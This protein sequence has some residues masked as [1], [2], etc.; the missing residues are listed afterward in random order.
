FLER[1]GGLYHPLQPPRLHSA[2]G[3]HP[4]A[5]ARIDHGQRPLE[6]RVRDLLIID[7]RLRCAG[8]AHRQ[9]PVELAWRGAEARP[10]QQMRDADTVVAE[11]AL[12]AMREV[13]DTVEDL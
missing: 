4:A 9:I 6:R 13:S 8:G 1:S 7:Q 5:P 11:R 12:V 3:G 2:D 10:P